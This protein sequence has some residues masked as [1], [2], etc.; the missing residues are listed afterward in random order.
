MLD[1]EKAKLINKCAEVTRA[2]VLGHKKD[3]EK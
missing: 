1:D 2:L 3:I